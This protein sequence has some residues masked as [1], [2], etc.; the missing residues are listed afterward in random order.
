MRTL[1]AMEIENDGGGFI[2]DV[3]GLTGRARVRAVAPIGP[4][5]SPRGIEPE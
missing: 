2:R 1:T 4:L 5:S 3:S